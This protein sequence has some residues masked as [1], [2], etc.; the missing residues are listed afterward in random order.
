MWPF[1]QNNTPIYQQYAQAYDTGNY[2]YFDPAQ[3]IGH[4]TQFI[5]GAPPEMQQNLYQQ[6]FDRMPYEQRMMFAQQLPP[7][8]GVDPNNPWSLSQGMIRLGRE[9]PDMLQRILGHP[10]LLGGALALTGLVAKHMLDEHRRN[11]A[12][13][14]ENQG[15]Y[16]G[17]DPYYQNQGGYGVPG[18]IRHERR[19]E[20]E[21][22]NEIRREE[23]ELD[24]LEDRE[25]REER[26]HHHRDDW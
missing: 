17:G 14:Y 25:Y 10:V 22:H 3:A 24:R 23:R 16:G 21:L 26:H 2:N 18:E 15:G 11:E 5:Q 8:Y 6:H 4:L 20:R 13:R 12:Y 9:R 19:E 7:Q 1:D